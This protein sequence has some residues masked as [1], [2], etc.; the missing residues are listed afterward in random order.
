[1]VKLTK[2]RQEVFNILKSAK[3]PLS[4]EQILDLLGESKMNLSTIYRSLEYFYNAKIVS[5]SAIGNLSFYHINHD[6]HAHYFV[7]SVCNKMTAFDCHL[8]TIIDTVQNDY[9]FIVN[10][11][12][13]TLYGVCSN[14]KGA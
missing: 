5:K 10:H 7:C 9:G 8:D 4:A 11:H 13:L 14:C 12:D 6:D 1:M 2:K 3:K